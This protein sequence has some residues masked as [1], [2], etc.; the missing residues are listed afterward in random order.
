MRDELQLV[1]VSNDRLATVTGGTVDR[2]KRPCDRCS[3]ES[4]DPLRLREPK[5]TT[6]TY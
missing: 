4:D 3:G 2:S 6:P 1:L 5:T